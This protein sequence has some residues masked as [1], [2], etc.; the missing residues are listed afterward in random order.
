MAGQFLYINYE[1][2]LVVDICKENSAENAVDTRL[3]IPLSDTL[4]AA[5]HD[6]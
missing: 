4:Q 1:K 3:G 6:D 2:I 5:K